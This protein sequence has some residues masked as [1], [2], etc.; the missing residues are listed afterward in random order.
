MSVTCALVELYRAQSDKCTGIL[1]YVH[2]I[3]LSGIIIIILF[4]LCCGGY[5]CSNQA[6]PCSSPQYLYLNN[7]TYKELVSECLSHGHTWHGARSLSWDLNLPPSA[8]QCNT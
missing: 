5:M 7:A 1:L 8:S 4:V 6:Q 3:W 2:C